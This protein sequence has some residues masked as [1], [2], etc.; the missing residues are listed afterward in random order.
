MADTKKP[1]V[2]PAKKPVAKTAPVKVA[3]PPVTPKSRSG[4]T[5][6]KTP[7][8]TPGKPRGK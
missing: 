4:G 5:N 1:P 6:G 7:L 8:T 3:A 2:A